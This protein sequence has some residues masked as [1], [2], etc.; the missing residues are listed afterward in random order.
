[1]FRKQKEDCSN[2]AAAID[3]FAHTN[4]HLTSKH[5]VSW[6]ILTKESGVAASQGI[7]GSINK[8]HLSTVNL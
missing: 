4:G 8:P 2:E 5:P 7:D 6:P 1:M 3:F